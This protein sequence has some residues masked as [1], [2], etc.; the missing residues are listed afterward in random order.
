MKIKNKTCKHLCSVIK[1]LIT[2]NTNRNASSH[3]TLFPRNNKNK[4]QKIN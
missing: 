3:A 2:I 1:S 4:N